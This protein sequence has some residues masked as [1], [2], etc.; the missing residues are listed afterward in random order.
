MVRKS[1]V[2]WRNLCTEKM[3][4]IF[5]FQWTQKFSY[6]SVSN[7]L[8]WTVKENSTTYNLN[9][10]LAFFVWGVKHYSLFALCSH[11]WLFALFI[12]HFA[13]L[14][15]MPISQITYSD[16]HISQITNARKCQATSGRTATH[17]SF[18]YYIFKFISYT[19]GSRE[20]IIIFIVVAQL[21]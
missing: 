21:I 3:L 13:C 18:L 16:F 17:I 6:H 7:R 11:S 5:L 20:M 19:I 12:L 9:F 8:C 14:F 4:F 2:S 1:H 15:C 10:F